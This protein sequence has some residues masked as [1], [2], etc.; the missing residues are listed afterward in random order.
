MLSHPPYNPDMNP[1]D[2]ELF[3]QLKE[4]TLG[5]RYP[6]L[7]EISITVNQIIR[8]MNKNGV[9]NGIIQ[10]P[11]RWNSVIQKQSDYIEGL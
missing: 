11:R 9:L 1:P 10:L 2:I 8:Q 5:R 4:P 3:P 7:E 6:S